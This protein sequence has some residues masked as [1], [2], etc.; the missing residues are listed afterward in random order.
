M[1]DKYYFLSGLMFGF[2][3]A[4]II[5]AMQETNLFIRLFGVVGA[6]ILLAI[7]LLPFQLKKSK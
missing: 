6:S 3:I 7:A 1:I 4:I 2:G 5:G